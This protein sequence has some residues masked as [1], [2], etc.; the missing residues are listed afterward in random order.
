MFK[1]LFAVYFPSINHARSAVY[2][3]RLRQYTDRMPC[4]K[5]HKNA[6][7]LWTW[8]RELEENLGLQPCPQK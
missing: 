6:G 7:L 5:T 4:I 3:Q 2:V 8:I 1:R